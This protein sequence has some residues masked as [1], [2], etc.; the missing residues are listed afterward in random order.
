MSHLS[1]KNAMFLKVITSLIAFEC[2]SNA[3]AGCDMPEVSLILPFYTSIPFLGVL[4]S[5]ALFPLLAPKLWHRFENVFLSGWTFLSLSMLWQIL[6]GY[7]LVSTLLGVAVHEYLPFII[8][9]TTL[10][11]IGSGFHIRLKAKATP[12]S[13]ASFLFVGS[14]LASLIGTTG[15]AMLLLRP[16]IHMNQGRTYRVHSIIF[17]IFIVAN[18]GGCLTPLGDPPLFLGYLNGVDFFWPFRNLALPFVMTVCPL[19]IAY[20]GIDSW[21]AS[22]ESVK[23]TAE[24][25][26]GKFSLEG[27]SNIILLVGV[28]IVL[29]G[30]SFIDCLPTYLILGQQ[31]SSS[32]IL[33]DII[34][35]IFAFI[36]YRTTPSSIHHHQ[37]FSWGPI[38]EVARVFAAIFITMIPLSIMLGAG[39][40]GPFSSLLHFTNTGPQSFI[41]FWLTGIFSAFLDNAPTYLI[42]FKMAGGNPE[43]LM[44][45]HAKTL[46][47]ISLGAVFMGAMTYIGNAPNFMVRS[48]AKQSGIVMPS[49]LGYM[50]WSCCILLPLFIG[51]TLWLFW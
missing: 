10:Y 13:N 32:H 44:T 23:V 40:A 15:A 37:H 12:F 21:F 46:M 3:W 42:F 8:L 18:I 19:L 14:L 7:F 38:L 34:L 41:Y 27:K 17:F 39:E 35:L 47:A 50:G 33:R 48:I 45:T 22:K 11:I 25:P 6:G 51:V 30:S 5:I 4:L 24:H 43:I 49:F 2:S 29:I 20:Y 28:L 36:S 26:V 16:F 31:V 9:L 1:G